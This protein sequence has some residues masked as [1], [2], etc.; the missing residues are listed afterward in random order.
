MAWGNNPQYS[1]GLFGNQRFS[2]GAY[3]FISAPSEPITVYPTPASASYQAQ[4]P[5]VTE[6]VDLGHIGAFYF[7]PDIE[8]VEP[9][10][11]NASYQINTPAVSEGK[12]GTVFP[13]LVFA[14]YRIKDVNV[15]ESKDIDID[16]VGVPRIGTS[17]LTV[18]FTATVTF[19]GV[20]A[21]LYEVN[22]YRWY[23]DVDNNPSEYES[24]DVNTITHVY[25]GYRG[26]KYSPKL[27][28]TLKRKGS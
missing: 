28:I 23:F 25:T 21:D 24:S 9:A 12:Q 11:S 10:S 20:F 13:T 7:G 14:F 4:T 2:I 16:F 26:Q 3:Y 1:T 8:T 19:N 15:V 22:Q 18:D 5:T 27:C 6:F 17:P